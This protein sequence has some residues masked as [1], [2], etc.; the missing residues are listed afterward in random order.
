VLNFEK[1][2]DILPGYSQR[3]NQS[4]ENREDIDNSFGP[5]PKPF[6]EEINDDMTSLL[7]AIGYTER[8]QDGHHIANQF[9]S[10]GQRAVEKITQTD[11]QG[12]KKHHQGQ[13]RRSDG[14]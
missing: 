1:V 6:H 5:G 9:E 4:Y 8:H 2:D 14:T 13:R 12:G 10:A 7:V 11:V 3:E